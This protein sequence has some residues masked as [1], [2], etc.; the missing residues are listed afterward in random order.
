M[1]DYLVRRIAQQPR[2]ASTQI[3]LGLGLGLLAIGLRL[4][5]APYIGFGAPFAAFVLVVLAAT[6]FGGVKAGV[7]AAALLTLGGVTVLAPT[8]GPLPLRRVWLGA[9]FF[10]ASSGF[11]IWIVALLR[12]ALA[13]EVT[14]REGER[15]LKLEMHHRVKNTLA[16]VQ[17]L[18]DQT[19]R[20]ASDAP[21][22]RR[23][24]TD[25]LTALAAAHDLLIDTG[26]RPV[27]MHAL[28]AR[29]LAPFGPVTSPRIALMGPE[30]RIGPDAAV[31]LSLCLHELATNAVK[32]G[33]LSRAHGG[34]RLEWEILEGSPRNLA[35]TWSEHGGPAPAPDARLG[36]GRRL[37]AQALAAQ[38]G[39][40]S[41]LTFERDGV[42]WTAALNV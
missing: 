18:A 39:G 22:A 40:R 12:A 1:T 42:R 38:P 15:L 28:A 21:A 13:R 36:F 14:A 41:D 31:S 32:H 2:R 11:A 29:V 33:A 19:F 35:L 6:V 20:G 16:V 9:L 34:V 3:G 37:L 26:W 24:F 10:L 8:D 23:D 5:L 25:R 17:A 27:A 4:A 30:V 7:S